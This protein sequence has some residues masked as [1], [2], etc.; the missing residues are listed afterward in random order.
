MNCLV[1][2]IAA[3]HGGNNVEKPHT[4]STCHKSFAKIGYLRDHMKRHLKKQ[5][6]EE[7]HCQY[8]GA[9]FQRQFRLDEHIRMN[10]VEAACNLCEFVCENRNVLRMH[11]Q[12]RHK[13]VQM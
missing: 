7:L 5:Q 3:K 4:C 6:M 1:K 10:H 12:N 11:T 8:C 9:S 13:G 2:H